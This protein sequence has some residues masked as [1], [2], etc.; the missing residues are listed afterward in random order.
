M[1]D[2]DWWPDPA[3]LAPAARKAAAIGAD[4]DAAVAVGVLNAHMNNDGAAGAATLA[5]PSAKRES[6]ARLE[7]RALTCARFLFVCSF[8]CTSMIAC[9]SNDR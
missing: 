4:L 5:P 3:S 9:V 7:V 1:G 6:S 8:P 2:A